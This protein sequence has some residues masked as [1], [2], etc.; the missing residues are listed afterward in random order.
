MEIKL[1]F[2]LVLAYLSFG[3]FT[4]GATLSGERGDTVEFLKLVAYMTLW[5]F[6][7]IAVIAATVAKMTKEKR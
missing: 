1:W 5:P 3:A 4:Y 6:V 7:L 2:G